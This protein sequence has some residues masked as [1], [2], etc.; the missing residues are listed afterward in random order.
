MR[1]KK[2]V[3]VIIQCTTYDCMLQQN[4]NVGSLSEP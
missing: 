2:T 3:Y 1:K 4:H